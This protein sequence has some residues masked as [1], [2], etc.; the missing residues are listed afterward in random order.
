MRKQ[1]TPEAEGLPW[2]RRTRAN[3]PEVYRWSS[4]ITVR[5]RYNGNK[6]ERERERERE[7]Q[8]T[9]RVIP[10]RRAARCMKSQPVERRRGNG[11]WMV[12]ENGDR[13][14]TIGVLPERSS[15]LYAHCLANGAGSSLAGP[16]WTRDSSLPRLPGQS[17][18]SKRQNKECG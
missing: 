17:R 6:R 7:S 4:Y 9:T 14:W 5:H 15:F 12:I 11:R 3:F 10:R 8:R 18:L 13:Q 2:L 16:P 1:A